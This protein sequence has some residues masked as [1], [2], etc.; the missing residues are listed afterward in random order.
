MNIKLLILT[1]SLLATHLM[2]MA[3]YNILGEAS[4]IAGVGSNDFA[5][6][7]VY[8]N[9][10][11]ILTQSKNL[12]LDLNLQDTLRLD[13]RFDFAWGVEAL[14]GVANSVD[15]EK[16][17]TS[18]GGLT[19]NPQHPANIW[20]QQL[21]AEVKWRSLYLGVGMKS[22]NSVLV[23]RNL[24]SGDL[25]WS[26][27]ARGIPEIRIGFV[28]FQPV[29]FTNR[30]LQI[31]VCLSY[32]KFADKNWVRDH[33]S[34]ERG[35][36]NPGTLW[37]YKRLYFRTKPEAPLHA[38]FGFQMIGLF[39]GHTFWYRDGKMTED[40]NN[41]EGVRD[42]IN[43]LL[44]FGHGR[45]GY[46]TGDHKGSWDI[47]LQYRFPNRS[48]LRAY[49]QFFW[50]DGTG[51]SKSNGFDG[52]YGLEYKRPE[53][54]W[55]TGVVAEYLDFTHQGGPIHYDP[56]DNTQGGTMNSQV[57]G[58]DNYY[59]N[60]FYRS[61]T[62]YGMTIGT[63]LVMGSIFNLNGNPV[64]LNNKVRAF[65]IAAEGFITPHLQWI[66]KYTYRKAWGIGHSVQTLHPGES[67]SWLAGI[68]WSLPKLTG[69]KLTADVA[70]DY[71][72]LPMN[73]FGV[74]VGA[75]WNFNIKINKSIKISKLER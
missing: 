60:S 26:G 9:R 70:A 61:Y 42:F 62:N 16:Y 73:A 19:V 54:G 27:N 67:N 20:L 2:A 72:T 52:L 29:P 10:H 47:S 23:D 17:S 6:F 15:Y 35:K 28:D 63:P 58:G 46:K 66:A 48:T 43:M 64:L 13:K 31:D 74:Y 41:Y 22:R 12:Y 5:P 75:A 38:K 56:A 59:N 24:S 71:G 51:M 34:Y 45:E 33:Y 57:R 69:L 14:G 8:S 53:K 65:H 1:L 37:T 25:V 55:L 32:G 39:G 11:G 3:E 40:V 44:P 7:E 18:S 49:T 4:V 30:W 50:E 21:Y 68:K 36:I